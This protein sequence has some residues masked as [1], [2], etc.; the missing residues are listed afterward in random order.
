[1]IVAVV[2]ESVPLTP[3]TVT[4]KSPVVAELQDKVDVPEPETEDGEL[5]ERP[6][7]VD[8]DTEK[9][10]LPEKPFRAVVVSEI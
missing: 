2:C 6:E 7:G 10:T 9:P 8:G 5:H 3:V 1:M 4:E